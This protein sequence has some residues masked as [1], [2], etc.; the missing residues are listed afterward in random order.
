MSHGLGEF[1]EGN[2]TFWI[3]VSG[4]QPEAPGRLL[5]S[6]RDRKSIKGGRV[7]N[8][9]HDLFLT[10]TSFYNF[11][12]ILPIHKHT[13]TIKMLGSTVVLAVMTALAGHV[14]AQSCT[15]GQVYCGATLMRPPSMCLFSSKCPD[16]ARIGA[17]GNRRPW[18]APALRGTGYYFLVD[19]KHPA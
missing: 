10:P 18:G 17:R 16:S 4:E 5:C 3:A 14:S 6:R 8:S 13:N 12:S 7:F 11:N 19:E 2:H 1:V 9:V 15:V